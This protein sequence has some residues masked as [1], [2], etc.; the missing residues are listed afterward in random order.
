MP[1]LRL[2]IKGNMGK[3]TIIHTK[4]GSFHGKI[5]SIN[6]KGIT[7][8][9]PD[10]YNVQHPSIKLMEDNV[11]VKAEEVVEAQ[12][13]FRGRGFRRFFFPFAFLLPFLFFI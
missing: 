1:D 12:D 6:K 5:E 7:V 13:F 4:S 11:K 8:L 9:L 3:W 10:F 2:V